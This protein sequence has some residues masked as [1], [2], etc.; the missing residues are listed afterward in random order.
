MVFKNPLDDVWA[1]KYA[2][3][4]IEDIV[5]PDRL[6]NIFKK[7][8]EDQTIP[9]L[10]LFSPTP[11]TGKTSMVKILANALKADILYLN[12][13]AR[14]DRGIGAIDEK[15]AKFVTNSS[16]LGDDI[17]KIVFI[18]EADGLT[19]DAQKSLK[20]FIE[21]NAEHVRFIFTANNEYEFI[22]AMYSRFQKISF[23]LEPDEYKPMINSF[24]K[25]VVKILNKENISFDEKIVFKIIN[26]NFPDYREVWQSL[27]CIYNSYGAINKSDNVSKKDIIK[28]IEA[29]DTKDLNVI[30]KTLEDIPNIN[31]KTIYSK[32]DKNLDLFKN[33][34]MVNLCLSLATWQY[35]SVFVADKMLNFIGF[36]AELIENS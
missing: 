22:D 18:D 28:I 11:G 9:N 25:R 29:I 23:E 24:M 5:L 21:K 19:I 3:K 20:S 34:T 12:G 13:S 30:R 8:I 32:L 36:C 16:I 17:R 7:F 2:P 27:Q 6:K 4:T 35:R 10:L 14:E 31:Y 15:V 33:Y 1:F 26:D